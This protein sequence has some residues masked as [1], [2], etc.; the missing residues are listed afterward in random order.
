MK[1]I[2]LFM[3]G[4][5]ISTSVV[6]SQY[7]PLYSF[8][9]LMRI[10]E[11]NPQMIV[12]AREM[13]S[14]LEIPHSI[15]LPQGIFIEARAVQNDR[16]VYAVIN[17]LLDIYDNAEVLTWQQIQNRFDLSVARL[18]YVKKATQNPTLGYNITIR[19]EGTQSSQY[20]LIPDWT[21]DA[22]MLFDA[23]TGDLLNQSFIIDPTNLSSPKQARLAPQ[24]FV[25]V[26]DQ[27]DD[28]V[29]SYDTMGTY[30]G[31]FAPAGGVNNAIL[32]NVRGH[33]YRPNGNL[34]VTVGSGGNQNAVAEFD[35]AGNYIGQFIAAGAGGLNSPFDIV[36]RSNDVLVNG[37]SSNKVHRY[38]LSGNYLNDFVSSGLAFPQQIHLESNGNVAVA[39][40]SPPSALYVYDSS[41][42]LL[43]SYNVITGLRGAYKL[44]NG[45]YIVT[46]GSGVHEITTSNTLVRT[47]VAGVS[48]QYVDFV[49]FQNIIPVELTSFTAISVG[50]NVE[51]N[52]STATE[53]NNRGFEIQRSVIPS[54]ARNLSWETA[55]FVDGKGTTTEPQNYAFVDKNLTSGK[56]AYR[57]KQIDFDGT[58]EYLPT[59]QAG[60]NQVEV[61]ILTPDKFTLEQNYPNP[62]NPTTVIS[63]QSPVS[64]W[65]TLKVYDVLGNEVVTL[66]NEYREA[67]SYKVEF[68]A[69]ELP[70]GVYYYKLSVGNFSDVKKMMLIK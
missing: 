11:E 17:N 28:V 41:G 65:Q 36:F 24:G 55:G 12:E 7:E 51:L 66:V 16:V 27:I 29:Q 54:G 40:F 18:N 46:N 69:S 47:I 35:N 70:S 43:A 25:S 52:W 10:T 13:T 20:L 3:V 48:A 56:Y 53:T 49:D 4:V 6:Y 32:D 5:L 62:F 23:T 34:V 33:N 2:F 45:N 1:R 37:S 57:L 58:F 50:N 61:E 15:Y 30:L 64:S 63:W 68:D 26:S 21:A 42:V 44:P 39:G 14:L 59:G 67:G 31:I 22:V 38:D 60:S 8:E 9:E 19:P